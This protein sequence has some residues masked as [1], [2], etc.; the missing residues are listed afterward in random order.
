MIISALQTL[1]R[2]SLQ[3]MVHSGESARALDKGSYSETPGA[4]CREGALPLRKW[5]AQPDTQ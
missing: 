3:G 2:W 4:L 1:C 5:Y